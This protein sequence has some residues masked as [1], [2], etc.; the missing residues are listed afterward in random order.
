MEQSNKTDVTLC[1]SISK[2][3]PICKSTQFLKIIH[4]KSWPL[5]LFDCLFGSY[6]IRYMEINFE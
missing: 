2:W 3:L 5:C 1:C 4:C 6:N